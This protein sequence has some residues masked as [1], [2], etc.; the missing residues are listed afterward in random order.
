MTSTSRGAP[1]L[2]M[3]IYPIQ[4]ESE[5]FNGIDRVVAQVFAEH[6]RIPCTM[7]LPRLTPAWPVM[8]NLPNSFL[9]TVYLFGRDRWDT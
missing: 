9:T 5:P 1:V 8:P 7:S 2:R 6:W 4:F 3:L